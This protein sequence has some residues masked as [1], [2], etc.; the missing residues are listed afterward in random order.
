VD[1]L[2][3]LHRFGIR[4]LDVSGVVETLDSIRIQTTEALAPT[5]ALAA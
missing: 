3:F 1:V 5:A 4:G 2:L